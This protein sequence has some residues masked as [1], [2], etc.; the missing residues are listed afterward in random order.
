MCFVH[1]SSMPS[2]TKSSNLYPIPIPIP[3]P[4]T[5]AFDRPNYLDDDDSLECALKRKYL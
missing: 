2:P 5:F 1:M 4:V 3:P